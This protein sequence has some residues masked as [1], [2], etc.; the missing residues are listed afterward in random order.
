MF[1]INYASKWEQSRAIYSTD[2]MIF[3]VISVN[4]KD[5]AMAYST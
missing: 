2:H 3:F 4:C 5:L 1:E